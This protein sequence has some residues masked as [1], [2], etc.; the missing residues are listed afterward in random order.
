MN[1][2]DDVAWDDMVLVG[3]VAR[4]HGLRGHV[5][6]NAVTDFAD[7]RFRAGAVVWARIADRVTPLRIDSVRMQGGRPVVAF[8]AYE[9][10]DRAETLAG[11]ELRVP[12]QELQPL[13]EG[14]WYH[15]QLVGCA[16]VTDGGATVGTVSKIDDAG[17]GALLVVNGE[18]G[19]ILIPLA[20][21]ICTAVDIERRQ[22]QIAPPEGLLELN[23]TR[24]GPA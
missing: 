16:V 18:R 8:D 10:V 22:I 15:H 14:V 1:E 4:T 3:I 21:D 13:A 23:E 7:E 5:I 9:D 11:L 12:E 19:E 6:L 2:H 20:E 17:G 24:K